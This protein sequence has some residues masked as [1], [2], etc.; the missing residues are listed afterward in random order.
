MKR[1]VHFSL[2]FTFFVLFSAITFCAS[3]QGPRHCN[4]PAAAGKITGET[5]VCQGEI[6]VIYTVPKIAH[7]TSYRWILPNG[8]TGSSSSQKIT[9]DYGP[10]AIS[11]DIIV[12]GVNS[13]GSGNLSRLPVKVNILPLPAGTINGETSTCTNTTVTYTV[14]E[15]P[16]AASYKWTLPDGATGSSNTNV[17]SIKFGPYASTAVIQV[18]GVN[19]CGDGQ[20]SKLIILEHSLPTSGFISGDTSICQNSGPIVYNDI[21]T[22]GA[23]SWEWTLPDGAAGSGTEPFI[24]VRYGINAR[25]GNITVKGINMCGE[26]PIARLKVKLN[27]PQAP[28]FIHGDTI[29]YQGQSRVIY[30]TTKNL[31]RNKLYVV[32]SIWILSYRFQQ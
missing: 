5:T 10:N 23:T 24:S 6:S 12:K 18:Q 15:I 17:I 31:N 9:V 4:K 7:A 28:D 19:E 11:G 3:G 21:S 14:S 25:S 27:T 30:S 29:V 13:C 20:P 32:L 2:L 8:A 16:N 22:S 1:S 26:A